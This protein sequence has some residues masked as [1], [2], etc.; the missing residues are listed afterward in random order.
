MWS[1]LVLWTNPLMLHLKKG[2]YRSLVSSYEYFLPFLLFEEFIFYLNSIWAA[3]LCFTI[4]FSGANWLT[5]YTFQHLWVCLTSEPVT[6]YL[7]GHRGFPAVQRRRRGRRKTLLNFVA[8]RGCTVQ[9]T[10]GQWGQ[11][12]WITGTKRSERGERDTEPVEGQGVKC[13]DVTGK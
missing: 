9:L 13:D 5:N 1:L 7:C 6:H 12:W 10:A 3:M 8:W 4:S 2:I 11:S